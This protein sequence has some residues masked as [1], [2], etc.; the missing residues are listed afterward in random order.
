VISAADRLVPD[1]ESRGYRASVAPIGRMESLRESI[2][3]RRRS[4]GFDPG[5]ERDYLSSFDFSPPAALPRVASIVL[6]AAFQPQAEV[7]FRWK[8]AT[9]PVRI[10]PT[11]VHETDRSIERVLDEILGP[12]GFRWTRARIPEKPLAV[13][14]G[15]ARYGRHNVAVLP[16]WGSFFRPVAFFTDLPPGADT[17]REDALLERCV[18]CRACRNAC[19]TKAI[20]DD[21]FTV[22]A[23]RCL[24][25]LNERPGDFPAWLDP[26][27]HH[28]LVG[29]MACQAA[30]PEN[31][32]FLDRI[33]LLAEFSES[34]TE[35]ILSS[36]Q[37]GHLSPE[38]RSK[39]ER[40]DFSEY[41]DFLG[42]NLRLLLD[43][44]SS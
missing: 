4:D 27:S 5:L 12:A 22:R 37:A 35:E 6:V 20:P 38:T 29:C 21:R 44:S 19:P 10:P 25:F 32:G 11:Y 9:V 23:E 31:R 34:E 26:A 41:L 14:S 33:E 7:R 28:C 18:A 42:R 1:L 15:L 24:T 2:E 40:L 17:W 30:C 13:R 8:G 36:R 43:S 39:F 16:G 3:T